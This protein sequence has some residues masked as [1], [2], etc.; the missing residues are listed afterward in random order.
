M[1][2]FLTGKQKYDFAMAEHKR[3]RQK[4]FVNITNQYYSKNSQVHFY[5]GPSQRLS[6]V[7]CQQPIKVGDLHRFEIKFDNTN[8]KIGDV[9]IYC[10]DP[11]IAA[12]QIQDLDDLK[13]MRAENEIKRIQLRNPQPELP[14]GAD[15]TSGQEKE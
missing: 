12:M 3:L 9:T 10:T 7:L 4:I 6:Y 1:A 2:D 11:A 13:K 5:D 8:V 15:L 14:T